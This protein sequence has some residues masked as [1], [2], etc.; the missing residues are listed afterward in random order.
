MIADM[1]YGN[2]LLHKKKSPDCVA[3]LGDRLMI[4]KND[5]EKYLYISKLNN[6]DKN[7]LVQS[8]LSVKVGRTASSSVM[9]ILPGARLLISGKSELQIFDMLTSV[10]IKKIELP[11]GVRVKQV[12]VLDEEKVICLSSKEFRVYNINNGVLEWAVEH[13]DRTIE[14]IQRMGV[15]VICVVHSNKT[16]SFWDIEEGVKKLTMNGRDATIVN[17]TLIVEQNGGCMLYR[18]RNGRHHPTRKFT[19]LISIRDNNIFCDVSITCLK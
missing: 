12:S 19:E 3:G 14:R 15:R 5:S 2:D 8:V 1:W 16:I 11:Q 4:T 18:F 7:V 17:D 9:T 10:L 13:N 6:V